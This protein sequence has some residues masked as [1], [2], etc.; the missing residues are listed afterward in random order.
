MP[1]EARRL[2]LFLGLLLTCS[3][4][5]TLVLEVAD[6]PKSKKEQHPAMLPI[7]EEYGR[8]IAIRKG[9]V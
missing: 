3:I 5:A 1:K 6:S 4:C 9:V 2:C 7:G 8:S